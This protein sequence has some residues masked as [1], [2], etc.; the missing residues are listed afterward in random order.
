MKKYF[1]VSFI[2]GIGL[3]FWA[4]NSCTQEVYE[5]GE[6]RL[7]RTSENRSYI[8]KVDI[9]ALVTKCFPGFTMQSTSIPV[10]KHIAIR[11]VLSRNRDNASIIFYIGLH[12]SVSA[13]EDAMLDM[14]N[15]QFNIP[16]VEHNVVSLGDNSWRYRL[17]ATV[18]P[19][20]PYSIA[21]IRKNA[22]VYFLHA[23]EKIE[24]VNLLPI[25]K[26]IDDALLNGSS[27]LTMTDT[28]NPPIV[29]SLSLSKN[30]V[31]E[32]EKFTATIQASDPEGSPLYYCTNATSMDAREKNILSLRPS[33]AF[34]PDEPF[35]GPHT[36]KAWVVNDNC[37]FSNIVE[38]PIIFSSLRGI[39]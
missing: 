20:D 15:S 35:Y 3:L 19:E 27:Y 8:S 10:Y 39:R 11:N 22:V 28:I 1:F 32:N 38:T 17:N 25:A 37:L 31:G 4:N 12:P 16:M 6:Y 2:I 33:R 13:A 5:K 18:K 26:A 29:L 7:I 30:A 14:L 24:D 21:F 36:I 23:A 34:F 9:P